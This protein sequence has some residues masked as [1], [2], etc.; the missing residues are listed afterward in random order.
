MKPDRGCKAVTF[1]PHSEVDV[2]IDKVF[3]GALLSL[4]R[5]LEYTREKKPE[6]LEKFCSDLT[7]YYNSL[8]ES[9]YTEW[10][11]NYPITDK[12]PIL[13]N[14]EGLAKSCLNYVLSLYNLSEDYSKESQFQTTLLTHRKASLAPSLQRLKQFSLTVN[15]DWAKEFLQSYVEYYVQKYRP[16]PEYPDLEKVFEA[17]AESFK[18]DTTSISTGVLF[19]KSRYIYRVDKCMGHEALKEFNE[20]EFGYLAICA[21]DSTIIKKMN[22]NFEFT[23]SCT[24]FDGPYCDGIAHDTR[25]VETVKHEPASFF[26]SLDELLDDIH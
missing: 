12:M 5:F 3:E 1:L 14:H 25:F 23:R 24:L 8:T 10:K 17:D 2:N 11:E 9:N 6:I 16:V 19:N 15:A 7:G 20:P 22:E 26:Q 18:T 13:E 21:G 4:E